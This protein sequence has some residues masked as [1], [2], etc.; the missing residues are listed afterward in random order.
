LQE[1]QDAF[2]ELGINI[3][4]LSYDSPEILADFSNRKG[5][6]FPLL[7]D[8]DSSS[9]KN[10]G[11]LNPE[12][13]GM[14]K[15]MAFPGT[16]YLNEKGEIEELFFTESYRERLT[17]ST[18]IAKLFP[19]SPKS[20]LPEMEKFRISQTGDT[21][22]AGTQWELLV[23]FPLPNKSHLYA[24]NESGNIPLQLTMEESPWFE[25]GEPIF[26]KSEVMDLSAIGKKAD[27]YSGN[28]TIRVP[29]TVSASDRVK[30]LKAPEQVTV[31]GKLSYQICTDTE[32]EMPQER[33]VQ[34]KAVIE[35]MDRE[36]V[37]P[38][39]QHK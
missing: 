35:P 11:L 9:I 24:P 13:S 5:I 30:S 18:M 26:P 28:V 34:W 25:F 32:C 8:P 37:E 20:G 19:D 3:V 21:G 23:T 16:I 17:P 38:G 36:R 39:L 10:L 4:G 6:S 7:A 1:S 29:V 12:G 15:G 31:T 27:V 2:K 33:A 22:V 14:T